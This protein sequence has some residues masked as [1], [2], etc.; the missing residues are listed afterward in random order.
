MSDEDLTVDDLVT[1]RA[2][3][4]LGEG[5]IPTAAVLIVETMTEDGPGIRYVIS[6]G[7]PTW[8]GIGML[9]SCLNALEATDLEQWGAEE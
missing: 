8:H 3:D 1:G 2:S 9:R 4:Q 6:H 5:R 7:V